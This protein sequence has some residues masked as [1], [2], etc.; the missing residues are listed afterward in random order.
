M[1][2]FQ[3]ANFIPRHNPTLTYLLPYH[4]NN[5]GVLNALIAYTKSYAPS[6]EMMKSFMEHVPMGNK[7]GC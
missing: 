3:D 4:Y 7:M 2:P 5:E 6:K 1:Q